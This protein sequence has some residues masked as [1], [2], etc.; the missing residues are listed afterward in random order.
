M[1]VEKHDGDLNESDFDDE[2]V[3][4]DN[5]MPHLIRQNELN[6]IVRDLQLS[7]SICDQLQK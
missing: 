3:I 6:D 1:R 4:K 5:M 2:F 7:K